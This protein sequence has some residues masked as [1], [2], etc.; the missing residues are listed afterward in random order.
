MAFCVIC[1][2]TIQEQ[3]CTLAC[4]HTFCATCIRHWCR[5]KNS[6]PCCR[7]SITIEC[8]L[9]FPLIVGCNYIAFNR[10]IYLIKVEDLLLD[11]G[12]IQSFIAEVR[13]CV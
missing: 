5:N 2:E 3:A 11:D 8:I 12:G 6:C 7:Q 13:F 1:Y 4:N 10:N 9:G